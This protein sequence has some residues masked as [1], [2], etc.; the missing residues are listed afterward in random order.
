MPFGSRVGGMGFLMS[1]LYIVLSVTLRSV[2][3]VHS[4]QRC[5][6]ADVCA[7]LWGF[8]SRVFLG[9]AVLKV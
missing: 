4:L 2:H 5:G 1:C 7:C 3:V 8:M 9:L 6:G